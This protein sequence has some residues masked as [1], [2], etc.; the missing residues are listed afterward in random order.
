LTHGSGQTASDPRFTIWI[1]ATVALF[2][3]AVFVGF[4]LLPSAQPDAGSLWSVICRAVGSPDGNSRGATPPVAGRPAS[5]IAWTVTTR[6]LMTQG[7]PVRGAASATTC[8]NCHGVNGVSND[9]AIPNLAGQSVAAIYKQLA[10][11]KDGRRNAAVMG[12]YVDPLSQAA[13]VDLAAYYASLPNPFVKVEI[14][15]VSAYPVAHQLVELGSPM[16]SVAS[17]AAC[18]GPLGFTFGAPSLRGQ[19]R[20]YLVQQMQALQSGDRRNDISEQMRSVARQL[21]EAE[22][23]ALAAYYSGFTS[24]AGP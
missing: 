11:F 17:C 4:I 6:E 18:H 21:T 5:T 2:V 7:N 8:N 23:A 10:D 24:I 19:Q 13:M 15:S 20:A 22:I 12:V 16:R 9:A 3:A 1:G 14:V